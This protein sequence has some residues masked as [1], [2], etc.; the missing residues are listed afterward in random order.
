MNS[1]K[2]AGIAVIVALVTVLSAS[3]VGAQQPTLLP[4]LN[5]NWCSAV[6]ASPPPPRFEH[7][8]G[9]WAE[10][11]QMCMSARKWDLGCADICGEAKDLWRMQKS[12]VFDKPKF[13]PP[14]SDIVPAPPAPNATPPGA[15][16]SQNSVV[17]A[18]PFSSPMGTPRKQACSM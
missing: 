8:T 11:R 9:E 7:H 1:V 3:R 12:G 17:S 10:A 2:R 16:A 13:S 14:A 15:A 18:A 4:P 6:P 5:P